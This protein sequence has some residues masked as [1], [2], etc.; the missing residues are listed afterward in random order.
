MS[1]TTRE[2]SSFIWRLIIWSQIIIKILFIC[3]L[4]LY[5]YFLFLRRVSHFQQK[6][7][8]ATQPNVPFCHLFVRSFVYLLV[9][10]S[11]G[12]VR[13]RVADVSFGVGVRS[14][15]RA[16]GWRRTEWNRRLTGLRWLVCLYRPQQA[17]GGHT[18]IPQIRLKRCEEFHIK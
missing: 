18:C 6:A 15:R 13:L 2:S 3:Y 1:A 8:V 14:P 9:A 7:P 4:V 11:V 5:C 12:V 10:C 16:V 17:G